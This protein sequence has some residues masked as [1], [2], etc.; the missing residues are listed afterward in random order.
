MISIVVKWELIHAVLLLDERLFLLRILLRYPYF[1]VTKIFC[2]MLPYLVARLSFALD[3]SES[4]CAVQCGFT[5]HFCAIVTSEIFCI[6]TK[7]LLVIFVILFGNTSLN[8]FICLSEPFLRFNFPKARLNA[9]SLLTELFRC[10]IYYAYFISYLF[11][12]FIYSYYLTRWN[13][14]SACFFKNKSDVIV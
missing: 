10:I 4:S 13:F 3:L 6:T 5:C 12:L 2:L 8:L 1:T 7:V 11:H 9:A 14:L